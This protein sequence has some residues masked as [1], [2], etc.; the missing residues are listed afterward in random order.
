MCVC[1]SVR[2]FPA[3]LY[4]ILLVGGSA[5]GAVKFDA[6]TAVGGSRLHAKPCLMTGEAQRGWEQKLEETH[7]HSWS[8]CSNGDFCFLVGKLELSSVFSL[9]RYFSILY[10]A[11][12][13]ARRCRLSIELNE[14]S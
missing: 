9:F 5:C 2:V 13:P 8:N 10:T 11:D 6:G 4:P 14:S 7:R 1:V 3:F 12:D